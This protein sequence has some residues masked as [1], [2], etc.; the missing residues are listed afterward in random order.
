MANWNFLIPTKIVFG[1]G[2]IEELA[3]I[4]KEYGNKVLVV[5]SLPKDS[6]IVQKIMNNLNSNGLNVDLYDKVTP[7]PTTVDI[8]EGVSVAKKNNSQ[9]IIG[10]GGGSSID[11]GKGVA[12]MATHDGPIWEYVWRSN[13]NPRPITNK[14]LPVIAIPTTSGT[15]AEVTPNAVVTNPDTKEKAAF[16]SPNNYAKVALLDPNLTIDLPSYL[17]AAT[18][19]DAL[20]HAIEAYIATFPN[21]ICE[22]FSMESIRTV[23]KYLPTAVYNGHDLEAREKM[24]WASMLAGMAISNKNTTLVHAMGHPIGGRANRGHGEAMAVCLPAVMRFSWASNYEKFAK[25]A[26]AM[27]INTQEMTLREKAAASV[28]AVENLLSDVGM[29]LCLEDIGINESM[30]DDLV[31]DAISYLKALVDIN[32]RVPSNEEIKQLY[33]EILKK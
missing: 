3:D 17:T 29:N 23:A 14:T 19:V 26:E 28:E 7:N 1:A 18:G 22:I 5:T 12:I 33:L 16:S 15:G 9:V 13:Y 27:G 21:P 31:Q 6:E 20:S 30:V 10:L 8:M 24:A 2:R 32:P 25:I 11:F 4:S